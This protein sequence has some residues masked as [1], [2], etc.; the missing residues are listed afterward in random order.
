LLHQ[1]QSKTSFGARGDTIGLQMGLMQ[2]GVDLGSYFVRGCLSAFFERGRDLG[3]RSRLSRF[4][5]R[6]SLQKDQG[7]ALRELDL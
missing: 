4:W 1:G 5:C 7:R 6:I 2:R 3:Q